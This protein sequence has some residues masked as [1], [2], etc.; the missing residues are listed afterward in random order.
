VRAR[1]G[2]AQD[3]EFD[4][5]KSNGTP[6]NDKGTTGFEGNTEDPGDYAPDPGPQGVTAVG[7]GGTTG[8]GIDNIDAGNH[9]D[10]PHAVAREH[11]PM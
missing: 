2:D 10:A 1:G 4:I 11:T 3:E 5:E 9:P 6:T 7:D 8:R